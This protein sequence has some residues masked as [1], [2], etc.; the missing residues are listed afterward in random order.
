MSRNRRKRPSASASTPVLQPV[1]F[2]DLERMSKEDVFSYDA[3]IAAE[4]EKL[5]KR[6]DWKRR[7]AAHMLARRRLEI[8]S[9]A[10]VRIADLESQLFEEGR[11]A[12]AATPTLLAMYQA[13][14]NRQLRAM[15]QIDGAVELP[16]LTS[17]DYRTAAGIRVDPP[18]QPVE[19]ATAR[20][21]LHAI[22][23]VGARVAE[24]RLGRFPMPP[25]FVAAKRRSRGRA[26]KT[27]DAAEDA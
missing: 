15:A 14:S 18:S 4:I 16:Q 11:T 17:E 25:V 13:F 1:T 10:S 20:R 9:S 8:V 21:V 5:F 6:E 12:N 24:R 22:E 27:P 7:L 23:S 3:A 26:A 19:D 2:D